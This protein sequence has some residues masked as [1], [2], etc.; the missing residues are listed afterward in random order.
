M[1]YTICYLDVL[2]KLE[3]SLFFSIYN[4]MK[5]FCIYRKCINRFETV[6]TEM[7]RRG[8]FYESFFMFMLIENG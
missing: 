7:P 1:H 2:K 8:A 4:Y 6:V 5:C 3:N